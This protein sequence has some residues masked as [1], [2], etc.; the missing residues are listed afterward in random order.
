MTAAGQRPHGR[1]QH[2]GRQDV[3]TAAKVKR[4][5]LSDVVASLNTIDS[6]LED[7]Y[8]AL[9][10]TT[11]SSSSSTSE[12]ESEESTRPLQATVSATAAKFAADGGAVA[13][14]LSPGVR[15]D[16]QLDLGIAF[17]SCVSTPLSPSSPKQAIGVCIGKAC[18]KRGSADLLATAQAAAEG[19]DVDVVPC[20]CL[21]QCKK[22]PNVQ[23]SIAGQKPYLVTGVQAGRQGLAQV[24]LIP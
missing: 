3:S 23:I 2:T 5:R 6:S 8:A 21:D 7:V 11:T 10:D 1:Q 9:E 13:E 14:A 20:K 19:R 18:T 17:G 4:Q 15:L 16:Q 22:G 12:S 24:G